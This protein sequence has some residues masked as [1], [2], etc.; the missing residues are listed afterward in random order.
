M[1][2]LYLILYNLIIVPV[3]FIGFRTGSWFNPKIK[4]GLAARKGMDNRIGTALAKIDRKRK[5]IL[6]HSA[7]AG[8]W[9]QALPVIEKMKSLHPD[10]YVVASFFSPS[11]YRF[12][13]N[14]SSVDL[15]VYLPLDTRS[16]AR[17]FFRRLKPDL[18]IISKLDIW[19]NHLAVATRMGIPVVVT[20]A[21]LAPDSGRD[22]GISA[23]FNKALYAR[24]SHF[25][26]IS[27][28]TR[29]RFLKLVPDTDRYTVTGDT[30]YDHVY[31]K[32]AATAKAGEVTVFHQPSGITLIAGSIWPQDEKHVLPAFGRLLLEHADVRAIIVPHEIHEPHLSAIEDFFAKINISTVRYSELPSEGAMGV[33]VVI[34]NAVGMLARLYRQTDIA[35]V[36]GGFGKGVHNVMEPAVFSQ[37][38]FFGPNYLTSDEASELLKKGGGFL[39]KNEEEVMEGFELFITNAAK[40]E[41]SGRKARSL[42]MDNV[43]ATD[44]TVRRITEDY[45]NIFGS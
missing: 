35:F 10:L 43:G 33:R 40:R 4:E 5:K 42:V 34:F 30:R 14:P 25:F 41:E 20:S 38:V 32:S 37:P 3:L 39:V 1:L 15:K 21:T 12:A 16:A 27:E 7:S 19:P 23:I 9:Q 11:G 8:E 29:Q 2:T 26:P 24:I 13:G 28:E 22:K 18:W 45:S 31:H 44:I 36:G 6:F 17:R